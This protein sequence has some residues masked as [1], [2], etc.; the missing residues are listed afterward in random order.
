MCILSTYDRINE[1]LIYEG[2]VHNAIAWPC[3]PVAAKNFAFRDDCRCF[4]VIYVYADFAFW[5]IVI[6]LNILRK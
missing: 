5:G 6:S 4:K 1:L 2:S 3:E